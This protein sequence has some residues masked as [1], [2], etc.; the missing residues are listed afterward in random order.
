VQES[1]HVTIEDMHLANLSQ[2]I[3]LTH[4]EKSI[5]RNVTAESNRG[6]GIINFISKYSII[7]GNTIRN[8][9]DG[10][11]SLYGGGRNNTVINNTIVENRS[12]VTHHQGITLEKERDSVI[13]NNTVKG[14]YYGIDIKNGTNSCLIEG[15]I[16][17]NN[18]YNIAIRPG[19]GGG[20]MQ[21]TSEKIRLYRNTATNQKKLQSSVAGILITVGKG[22]IVQENTIDQDGLLLK[23][24]VKLNRNID[25]NGIKF[26]DNVFVPKKE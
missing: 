1:K 21:E 20:N 17:F 4:S 26:I 14:F 16:A 7:E 25:L 8:S 11:L 3:N 13:K 24:G 5:V 9:G 15:N 12:A 10:H 6:S 18:Q 22:H 2:G 23:G 19:D